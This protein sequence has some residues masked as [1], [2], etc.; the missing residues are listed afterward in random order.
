MR[1]RTWVLLAV[2]SSVIAV[3]GCGSSGGASGPREGDGGG[4]ALGDAAASAPTG[5][6]A[7]SAPAG[8][9]VSAGD[10]G[11]ATIVEAAAPSTVEAGP[12]PAPVCSAAVAL[13]DTS[14][15]T[16]VVGQG[17][18]GGCTEAA[19]RSA[20]TQ[21]GV[22]T[23][24][25]GGPTTISIASEIAVPTDRDTVIDG[26]GTVTLDGGGSTRLLNFQSGDYRGNYGGAQHKLTVQRI[27]LTRAKA[28]GTMM[29]PA[30]SPPCSQ[31][32]QDGAGG[33]I[34]MTSGVLHVIDATFTNNQAAA[35]G[36]DVGGG[37][38]YTTGSTDTTIVGSQ[39]DG[40]SASNGGAVG[41][42]NSDL[43]LVNDTFSENEATGEGANSTNATCPVVGNQRETGSGGNGGAVSIDGGDDGTLTV[44]G[45][46]FSKNSGHAIGGA[47]FRT[48]DG[49]KQTSNID[50]TTFDGNTC[51][52]TYNGS[53]TGQAGAMYF[54]NSHVVLT[55]STASNNSA[56]GSGAFFGD[57]T[58]LDATNTTF[59]SNVATTGVGG[60]IAASG[61]LTNCTFANNE[62]HGTNYAA[63]AA[64]LFGGPW[65]IHNTI[66]GG[67]VDNDSSNDETCSSGTSNTGDHDLQWPMGGLDSPC[68][69]GITFADPMLGPLANHGGMTSTIAPGAAPSVVQTGTSCPASD[70]TGR[71]RANP[72]TLGAL[73]AP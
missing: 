15:P 3:G 52:G 51:S 23:F 10:D 18:A 66:F 28:S 69:P 1:R 55:N 35:L 19:L 50:R 32:Y 7:V 65:A 40:N 24:D 13:A 26:G 14:H 9:A 47:I 48:P 71:A 38:I 30:A 44:C 25:C 11:A 20:V 16:T 17:S 6:A 39:F 58:E 12:P 63:F 5:D 53:P 43:S 45:C 37:G 73:E 49:A 72:C 36:P 21:G 61:S 60:A 57:G 31:G 67:N 56:P 2:A 64:A 46:T 54:H 4:S 59:A 27:T 22:V 62:A 42:L 29:F 68:V 8:D 34:L 70:Q 33:A 41:S